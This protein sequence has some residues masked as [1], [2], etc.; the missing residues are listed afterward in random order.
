MY[1][2]ALA[3]DY[4]GTLAKEGKVNAATIDALKGV[5]AS[6]RKLILVTGRDLPI[7]SARS[8]SS[9]CST[10]WWPRTVPFSS[11][12]QERGD[13]LAEPPSPAFVARLR[14]LGVS[15]LSVGR[16]IVATWEPNEAAVLRA[17][18]DLALELHIVFNKGA[19]MVLRATSTRPGA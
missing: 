1:F 14:E 13:A 6:G 16:T 19:V 4:D 7:F 10:T 2:V 15:P 8:P 17:I 5:R 3:T 11:T 12:G 9:S 18:R